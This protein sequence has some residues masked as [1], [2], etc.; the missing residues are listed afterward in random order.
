ML[1]LSSYC[2]ISTVVDFLHMSQGPQSH[3]CGHVVFRLDRDIVCDLDVV[4]GAQKGQSVADT[5]DANVGECFVFEMYENIA[6]D[7]ILWETR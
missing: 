5:F 3:T 4:D 7:C 1:H 2:A 6:R